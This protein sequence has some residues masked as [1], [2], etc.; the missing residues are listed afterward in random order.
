MAR[1]DHP[2]IEHDKMARLAIG[3]MM[4]FNGENDGESD[5]KVNDKL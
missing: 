3:K 4:D 5:R 1:I 2:R